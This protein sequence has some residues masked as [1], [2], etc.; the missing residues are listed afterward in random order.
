MN[1]IAF[2]LATVVSLAF[3]VA[4]CAGDSSKTAA[5]AA[6]AP[7]AS[8][9]AADA[10]A[11]P[12]AEA[13]APAASADTAA[14]PA[15]SNAPAAEAAPATE[16]AA[17]EPPPAAPQSTQQMM[18]DLRQG[19]HAVN[20]CMKVD[21]VTTVGF[22]QCVDAALAAAEAKGPV[23]DA[24]TLGVNNRAWAF[25]GEHIVDMK[26]KG[27]DWSKQY[28][29][30]RERREAYRQTAANLLDKTGLVEKQVCPAAGVPDCPS[31]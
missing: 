9:P 6:A 17:A 31:K 5:P 14:A 22:T 28:R 23:S 13:N 12:A 7:D 24:Y 10:N 19:G 11:A 30:A 27:L 25:M 16:T 20:P 26:E 3:G 21:N 18:R 15:D 1:R 29:M 8:A 2:T 4:G